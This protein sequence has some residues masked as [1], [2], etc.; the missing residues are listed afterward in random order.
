MTTQNKASS[1]GLIVGIDIGGT[2]THLRVEGGE[3][4]RDRILPSDDWRVHDWDKDATRLLELV[5]ELSQGQPIAAIGVGAHGCD[6]TDECNA[7]QAAFARRTK[8]PVAVVNDAE[9][10]PLAMNL[11]GQIGLV[12]GTGAIAVCRRA[13][14]ELMVAGGWGWIIGDEGGAASLMREAIRAIARHLD[15]GGSRDEPLCRLAFETLEVPRPAR[16]GSVFSSLGSAARAGSYARIIFDAA[17]DGSGLAD[18]VIRAGGD[19]LANLVQLLD[20]RGADANAVVVGGGVVTHQPL[21]WNAFV[22]ALHARLGTRITP[23]LYQDKPV[24]GACRLAAS[25]V[26]TQSNLATA[27]YGEKP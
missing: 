3:D 21:L 5:D 4:V 6:D 11:P 7:F 24:T 9:L 12:A 23:H 10:M 19:A 14:G 26:E 22:E 1:S 15:A 25:L 16:L 27:P 18:R 8:I 17:A 2:K 20:T 13:D